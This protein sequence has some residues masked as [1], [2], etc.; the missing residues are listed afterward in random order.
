M[1]VSK[2]DFNTFKREFLRWA[3]I[4]NLKQYR[5]DFVFKPLDDNYAE[6]IISEESGVA[7]VYFASEL[8]GQD[9][10]MCRG[11]EKVA[12]HEVIHLLLNRLYW[13]GLQRF[14]G[15]SES[16]HEWEKLV[17]ILEKAL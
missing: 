6:I 4:L 17:R 11:P 12:K 1:K 13:L 5:Y 9:K 14:V 3:E 16:Q 8:D 7:T 10:D 15:S 2:A